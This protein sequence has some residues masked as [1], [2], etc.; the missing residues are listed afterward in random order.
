MNQK[1]SINV[2]VRSR[3]KNQRE[4]LME[5]PK[6]VQIEQN[7]ITVQNIT[8]WDDEEPIQ[9]EVNEKF[10]FNHVY[11]ENSQNKTIFDEQI[12]NLVDKVVLGYNVT[13]MTYGQTGA[14][15][16]F[17]L[18]GHPEVPGIMS[19]SV[20]RLFQSLSEYKDP[21][22]SC[23]FFEVFDEHTKKLIQNPCDQQ[24]KHS[25]QKLQSSAI[26]SF[27][28]F[29][30]VIES[31]K[32]LYTSNSKLYIPAERA[33]HVVQIAVK[34]KNKSC[35]LSFVDLQSSN[36]PKPAHGTHT[37]LSI[38]FKNV[39]SSIEQNTHIPYTK[40]TQLFQESLGGNAFC[41]VVFNIN[42]YDCEESISSLR[43]AQRVA[44]VMNTPKINT[45]DQP[46]KT[47]KTA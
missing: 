44:Q 27:A 16:S 22:V 23:S 26:R 2:I 8:K 32:K 14:G 13:I 37:D 38:S 5:L 24:E 36:T 1:Q 10:T 21:Q 11:D 41:T 6:C 4:K 17:T 46:Q 29:Q 39:I 33:S 42:P 45:Q 30:Q 20:Q 47:E 40:I 9:D 12:S 3:P 28:E 15:K 18:F 43:L 19:L 7:K 31:G 34:L 25:E 35:L